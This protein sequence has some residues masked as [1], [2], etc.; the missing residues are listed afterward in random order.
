MATGSTTNCTAI[1]PNAYCGT[2]DEPAANFDDGTGCAC[3]YGLNYDWAT[4]KCEGKAPPGG[5]WCGTDWMDATS[6]RHA[7]CKTD[8]DCTP[9]ICFAHVTC[10]R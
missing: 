1:D 10:R 8:D 9:L 6:C 5:S 2:S 7:Q 4:K 3:D